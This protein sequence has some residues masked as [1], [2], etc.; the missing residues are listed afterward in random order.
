MTIDQAKEKVAKE[1]KYVNWDSCINDQPNYGVEKIMDKVVL[2]YAS[3][4]PHAI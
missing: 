1:M 2:V 4:F 3:Q